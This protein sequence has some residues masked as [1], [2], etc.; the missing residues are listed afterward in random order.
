MK[1]IYLLVYLFIYKIVCLRH[2]FV[3]ENPNLKKTFK[4]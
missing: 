2:I 1:I 4:L 3:V